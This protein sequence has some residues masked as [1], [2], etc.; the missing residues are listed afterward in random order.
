MRTTK[1]LSSF[2]ITAEMEPASKESKKSINLPCTVFDQSDEDLDVSEEMEVVRELLYESIKNKFPSGVMADHLAK[3]YQETCEATGMGPP[4][5]TD[6]LNHIRVAEEFEVFNRGPIVMVYTRQ[7]DAPALRLDAIKNSISLNI[8]K[9]VSGSNG[10]RRQKIRITDIELAKQMKYV[11]LQQPISFSPVENLIV[12]NCDNPRS[13]FI[14]LAER[15]KDFEA[16]TETL[17]KY[18]GIESLGESVDVVEVGAVYSVKDPINGH[19]YR[20]HLEGLKSSQNVEL[21][22]MDCG[23]RIF[24]DRMSLRR[25]RAQFALPSVY[26]IY[27]LR[28]QLEP[29]AEEGFSVDLSSLRISAHTQQPVQAK[30]LR[31]H[32]EDDFYIV[33]ISSQNE[34][35]SV[36]GVNDIGTSISVASDYA[37]DSLRAVMILLSYGCWLTSNVLFDFRSSE[38]FTLLK[39][40]QRLT[41]SLWTCLQ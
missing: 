27:A 33:R 2:I 34:S 23:R 4:L 21:F 40:F 35:Q 26:P 15:R 25:L 7:R 31:R 19:W 20:A 16:L 30:F 14:H 8:S 13:I 22:L 24:V 41:S 29:N 12:L 39:I 1:N 18:Y 6:W 36:L 38:I 32:T 11:K 3:I 28:I 5:P 9:S 10:A 37:H 17:D